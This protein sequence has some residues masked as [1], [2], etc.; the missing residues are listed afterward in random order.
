LSQELQTASPRCGYPK[1]Y[2]MREKPLNLSH[3]NDENPEA[4][5]LQPQEESESSTP[6]ILRPYMTNNLG[7]LL[8]ILTS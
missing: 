2:V 8:K 4:G 5:A 3:T 6:I 1:V 7:T